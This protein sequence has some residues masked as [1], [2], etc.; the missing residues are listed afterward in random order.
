MA[1][2]NEIKR[3]VFWYG[4]R[5]RNANQAF[6]FISEK[7]FISYE[8]GV[9]K[10]YHILPPALKEKVDQGA[11]LSAMEKAVVDG[12]KQMENDLK[13]SQIERPGILMLPNTDAEVAEYLTTDMHCQEIEI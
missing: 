10:N 13:F 9:E 1:K 7:K 3:L 8:A 11:K 6:S 4:T 12:L 5:K 2:K